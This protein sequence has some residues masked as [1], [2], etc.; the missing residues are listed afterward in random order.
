[1]IF[2]FM[3][4]RYRL[5]EHAN[6]FEQDRAT[7]EIQREIGRRVV[8]ST[9]TEAVEIEKRMDDYFRKQYGVG[10]LRQVLRRAQQLGRGQN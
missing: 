5:D 9:R 3:L 6:L 8:M 4:R 1:V 2:V 7:F 10:A